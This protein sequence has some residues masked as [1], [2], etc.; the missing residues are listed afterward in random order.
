MA[1]PS[2][3]LDTIKPF[4]HDV[5]FTI[6][7]YTSTGWFLKIWN[8]SHTWSSVTYIQTQ[9]HKRQVKRNE[10]KKKSKNMAALMIELNHVFV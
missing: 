7:V 8:A 4:P 3:I 9:T 1:K 10:F 6:I 2:A 5:Q